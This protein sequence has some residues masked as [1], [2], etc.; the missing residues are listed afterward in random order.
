[1]GKASW[2]VLHGQVPADMNCTNKSTHPFLL[3]SRNADLA[4]GPPQ[5][6]S[7]T[8][9]ATRQ[10]RWAIEN[11]PHSLG[12][13][14]RFIQSGRLGLVSAPRSAAS[15]C[16]GDFLARWANYTTTMNQQ[17]PQAD[18]SS[19]HPRTHSPS[20]H[21]TADRRAGLKKKHMTVPPPPLLNW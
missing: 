21:G 4:R 17:P 12:W 15:P 20:P 9:S 19:T 13:P 6:P 2:P 10:M 3:S 1:M 16:S 18:P 5:A 14:N 7:I 11:F 8:T